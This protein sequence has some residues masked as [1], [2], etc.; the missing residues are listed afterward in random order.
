MLAT[1][2]AAVSRQEVW[3]VIRRVNGSDLKNTIWALFY[4]CIGY[5]S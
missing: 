5:S 1:V 3:I 4:D 2:T